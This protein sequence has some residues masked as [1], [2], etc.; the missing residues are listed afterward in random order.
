[1]STDEIAK[2][3]LSF[4][5][6]SIEKINKRDSSNRMVVSNIA[7][8]LADEDGHDFIQSGDTRLI[9]YED[10][11]DAIIHSQD[12]VLNDHHFNNRHAHEV[13]E[14]GYSNMSSD[15]NGDPQNRRRFPLLPLEMKDLIVERMHIHY[16]QKEL[17]PVNNVRFYSKHDTNNGSGLI[18]KAIPEA[19]YATLLPKVFEDFQVRV[20]CRSIEKTEVAFE[21]FSLWCS[22][23]GNN[24]PFLSQS[25]PPVP[26]TP[27]V[28][29]P[30]WSQQSPQY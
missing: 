18:G 14:E 21:A 3:I 5:D 6:K 9:N 23:V 28:K 10:S 12:S 11:Y 17:N 16:G 13:I 15:S 19:N 24:T 25:Y 2:Q 27:T 1:M 20:F 30:Y 22:H 7:A 26:A 8:N 4:S 29:S